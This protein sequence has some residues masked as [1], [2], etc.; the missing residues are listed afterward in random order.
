[1]TGHHNYI[2]QKLIAC[3]SILHHTIA[4]NVDYVFELSF[5][6]ALSAT[7]LTL[8]LFNNAVDCKSHLCAADWSGE[9]Y[10]YLLIKG[11]Q[12]VGLAFLH[13]A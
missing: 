12:N 7:R 5:T 2:L 4:I 13:G 9:K 1:M 10:M 8:E 6:S 3:L 11:H